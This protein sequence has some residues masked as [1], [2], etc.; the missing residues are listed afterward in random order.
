MVKTKKEETS[1]A[2]RC[3]G[4]ILTL[5]VLFAGIV[6]TWA[7]YGKDINTNTKNIGC[8][9]EEGSKLAAKNHLD[10]V[11]LRNDVTSIQGKI[12]DIDEMRSEQQ[13]GFDEILRRLPVK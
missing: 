4:L 10:V 9:K 12:D 13:A 8:I 1:T 7:I 6:G 3:A 11:I 2:L 5:L